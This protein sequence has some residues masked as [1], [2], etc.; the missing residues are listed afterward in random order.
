VA[1]LAERLRRMAVVHDTG[2][3]F[4]Y[5]APKMWGCNASGN[6]FGLQPKIGGSTPPISTRRFGLVALM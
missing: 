4:S 6:I 2:V 3:R 1:G 5:S